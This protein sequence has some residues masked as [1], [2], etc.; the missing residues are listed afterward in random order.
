MAN[1]MR[2]GMK[3]LFVSLYIYFIFSYRCRFAVS[4]HSVAVCCR[5]TLKCCGAYMNVTEIS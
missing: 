2:N 4:T 5:N 1:G 3:I